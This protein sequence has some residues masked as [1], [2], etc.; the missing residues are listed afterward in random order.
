M[1][2]FMRSVKAYEEFNATCS[3]YVRIIDGIMLP[4]GSTTD[5]IHSLCNT[6]NASDIRLQFFETNLIWSCNVYKGKN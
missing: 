2:Y 3:S 1:N 5:V 6:I 4:D